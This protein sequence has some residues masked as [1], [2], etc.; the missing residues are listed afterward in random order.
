MSATALDRAVLLELR[1]GVPLWQ[2]ADL[3]AMI[4]LSAVSRVLH[5]LSLPGFGGA[6]CKRCPVSAALVATI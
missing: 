3:R 6:R 4:A 2:D 5:R 1:E